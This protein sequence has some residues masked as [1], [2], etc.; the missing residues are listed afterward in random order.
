MRSHEALGHVGSWVC[1]RHASAWIQVAVVGVQE[2]HTFEKTLLLDFRMSRPIVIECEKDIFRICRNACD[3][4]GGGPCNGHV[5]R[6]LALKRDKIKAPK[7][8]AELEFLIAAQVL[9]LRL[10]P[11]YCVLHMCQI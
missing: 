11:M 9:V 2:V 5:L 10:V 4:F 3:V 1:L 6:C 7:C 8:R